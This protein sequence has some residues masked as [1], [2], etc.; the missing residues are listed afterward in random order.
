M[1]GG[2]RFYKQYSA[3]RC[4][5]QP[6]CA[7][8]CGPSAAAPLSGAVCRPCSPL[9]LTSFGSSPAGGAKC[10]PVVIR[11]GCGKAKPR[12]TSPYHKLWAGE[13]TCTCLP[14][15][16]GGMSRQRHDGEGSTGAGTAPI[17]G[18]CLRGEHCRRRPAFTAQTSQ[19]SARCPAPY[20]PPYCRCWS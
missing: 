9:S 6:S 13:R 11:V 19:T 5:C 20:P 18:L 16:G 3:G 12:K 10:Q 15:G 17:R 7:L 2:T 8:F 1:S 4:I 14:Q